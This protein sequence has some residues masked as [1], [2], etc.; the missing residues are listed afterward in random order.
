MAIM[1]L[2]LAVAAA[3]V[4][5]QSDGELFNKA[6]LSLFDKQWKQALGDLD[7]L[8]EKYP[9]S[10]FAPLALFYKARC[11]EE[12]GK[13]LKAL[14]FFERF[15]GV[16]DNEGL[17]EQATVS[18]IDMYAELGKKG[19]PKYYKK[20]K[21]FLEGGTLEVRYYSAFKLS[22]VKDKRIARAAVP[23]LKRIVKVETDQ[24]LVDR[25]NIALMRIDPSYLKRS[26]ERIV[27]NPTVL[28]IRVFNKQSKK[29]SLSLNIPFAL[30]RLALDALPE[31]DREKLKKAGY[32]ID[33]IIDSLVETGE[34]LKIAGDEEVLRI[35][36]E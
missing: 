30:A 24:E 35:W 3:P 15:V 13:P 4:F 10:R 20:V 34:I 17:R 32:N 23:V 27:K 29:D 14:T 8:L 33:S 31:N 19:D 36:I 25:A 2:I 18:M 22:Y 11:Y 21:G 26:A 7:T 6:K 28:K 12:T 16:S 5:G 1:V 9:D